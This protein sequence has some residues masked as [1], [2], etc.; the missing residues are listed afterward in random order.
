MNSRRKRR[1]RAAQ[2]QLRSNTEAEA[3][4]PSPVTLRTPVPWVE[5]SE[6]QPAPVRAASRV[7]LPATVEKEME[8][9]Q[10]PPKR[11][12]IGDYLRVQAHVRWGLPL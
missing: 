1:L 2:L 4:A 11:N 8:R 12:L 7:I 6:Y 5:P 9:E 3:L 10:E